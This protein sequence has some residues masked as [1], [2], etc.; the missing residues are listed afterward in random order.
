MVADLRAGAAVATLVLGLSA[1]TWPRRAPTEGVAS[2]APATVHRVTM[3]GQ[4]FTPA[5]IVAAAGDS[6]R[7]ELESGGPHN[8]AFDPDSI[9]AGA[10][11]ALA[12]NLGSEPRF[13]VTPEMLIDRGEA[14]TLSLSGLPPGR[15]YFYC[16]P[17]VGGGM[18]GELVI[19]AP[20]D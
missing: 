9:P 13:L 2:T 11:A 20:S 10:L 18:K 7:F 17:H 6:L 1:A 3:R 19:A 12:R 4:R 15:Y 5:R 16:A 14:F 8:V